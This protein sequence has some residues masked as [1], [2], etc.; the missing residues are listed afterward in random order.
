MLEMDKNFYN[1]CSIAVAFSSNTS[2]I[3]TE[4]SDLMTDLDRSNTEDE[5]HADTSNWTPT[6]KEKVTTYDGI[7]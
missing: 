4:D 7:S 6:K 2:P 5:I 1:F 3:M